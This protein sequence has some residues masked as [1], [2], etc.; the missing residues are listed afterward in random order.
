MTPSVSSKGSR[1]ENA[2]NDGISET[3][4][5]GYTAGYTAEAKN[6][7]ADPVTT[8]AAALMTLSE[9]DRARLAAMLQSE[10]FANNGGAL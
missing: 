5:N 6:D 8:L 7:N 9:T 1:R 2:I 10:G 3:S 4:A